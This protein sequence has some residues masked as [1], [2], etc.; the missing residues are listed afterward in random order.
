MHIKKINIKNQVCNYYF[1]NLVKAK[2]FETKN[3]SIDEKNHKDLTIYIIRY[4]HSKSIK[5]LSL[6]YHELMGKI[7]EDEGLVDDYMLD[8]VLVKIKKIM[9][10][11]KFDDTKILIDTDDKLQTILP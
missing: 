9:G 7:K 1:D 4:I 3:V 5:M 8:K 11:E 6:H 2:K 10:I